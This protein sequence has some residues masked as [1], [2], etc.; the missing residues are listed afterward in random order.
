MSKRAK[1][2]VF[3]ENKILK[4][5]KFTYNIFVNK[6]ICNTTNLLTKTLATAAYTY[7]VYQNTFKIARE[8]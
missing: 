8:Y 6:L 7:T 2:S 5:T 4:I 3:S 1:I